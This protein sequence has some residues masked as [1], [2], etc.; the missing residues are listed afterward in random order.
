MPKNK[1]RKYSKDE[2]R[3]YWIGVGIA[4]RTFKD[5]NK[6]LY[7]S[8]ENIA[9]SARKGFEASNYNDVGKKFR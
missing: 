7:S 9:R 4:E 6:I 2:I 8:N 3:A 5:H 1:K